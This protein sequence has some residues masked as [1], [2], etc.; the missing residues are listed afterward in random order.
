LLLVNVINMRIVSYLLIVGM[1]ITSFTSC[2]Y[3]NVEELYPQVV[4]CDTLNVTYSQTIASIMSASCNGCHG[5]S[6][7]SGNVR[8]DTYDGLK[9]VADNGKLWGAVNHDP[10]YSPMPKDRPKLNECDLKQ[11]QIWIDNGAL[12]D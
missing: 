4:E 6:A 12:D 3:D 9:V 1:M 5:G 10:G 2:Y 7:P 11:I 8:T